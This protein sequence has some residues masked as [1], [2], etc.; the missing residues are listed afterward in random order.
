MIIIV[1]IIILEVCLFLSSVNIVQLLQ[2]LPVPHLY[3][4][5]PVFDKRK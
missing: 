1:I 2:S 4:N 3:M 5:P